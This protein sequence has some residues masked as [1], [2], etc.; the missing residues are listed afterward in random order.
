MYELARL[1]FY[2]GD[3]DEAAEWGLRAADGGHPGAQRDFRRADLA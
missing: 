1:A 2:A 3:V